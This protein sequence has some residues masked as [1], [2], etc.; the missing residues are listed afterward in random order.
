MRRPALI[1]TSACSI[2]VVLALTIWSKPGNSVSG[3][4]ASNATP[5]SFAAGQSWFDSLQFK[6]LTISA[7]LP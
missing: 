3:S 5:P 4:S 7:G 2:A 6:E 1:F